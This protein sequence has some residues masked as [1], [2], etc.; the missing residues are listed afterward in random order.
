MDY[1]NQTKTFT[2]SIVAIEPKHSSG[3]LSSNP[4]GASIFPPRSLSNFSRFVGGRLASL[5][6]WYRY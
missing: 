1:Q 5:L 2:A 3:T 6:S 4:I